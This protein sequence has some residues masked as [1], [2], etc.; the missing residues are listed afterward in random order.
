[1]DKQELDLLEMFRRLCPADRNTVMI[2]VS[3]AMTAE[4]AVRREYECSTADSDARKCVVQGN[5]VVA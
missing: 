1:M 5:E 3:M 2:A 4:E